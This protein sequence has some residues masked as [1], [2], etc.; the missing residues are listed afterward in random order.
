MDEGSGGC[1]CGVNLVVT[2]HKR[3]GDVHGRN[4]FIRGHDN[5]RIGYTKSLKTIGHS[6]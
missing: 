6:V 2:V 3:Q 1:I 4:D 5:F